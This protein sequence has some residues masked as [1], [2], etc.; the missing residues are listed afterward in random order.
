MLTLTRLKVF[1]KKKNIC[2][3][4]Q[5]LRKNTISECQN[6]SVYIQIEKENLENSD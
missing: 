4:F 1:F 2:F 5:V 3:I 6:N